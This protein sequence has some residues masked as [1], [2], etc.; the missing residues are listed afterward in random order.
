MGLSDLADKKNVLQML[1]GHNY[2]KKVFIRNSSLP[3][4]ASPVPTGSPLLRAFGYVC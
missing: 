1:R 4:R 3:R 2:T